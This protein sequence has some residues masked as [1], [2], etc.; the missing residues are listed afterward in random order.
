MKKYIFLLGIVFICQNSYSFTIGSGSKK[1][2]FYPIAKSLCEVYNKYYVQ[3]CTPLSTKGSSFNI[4]NVKE[5]NLDLGIAQKSLFAEKGGDK[6]QIVANLH[7]EYFTLVVGKNTK[8]KSFK[9]LKNKIINIGN[10]G[11]GSRIF[12]ERM[13]KEQGWK[14]KDFKEIFERKS[15]DLDDLICA[16]KIDA[17]VY[18][19]GHPNEVFTN[20]AECEGKFVSLNKK[21]VRKFLK[22][23]D[24]S[25][26]AKMPIIY[27]KQ[28]KDVTTIALPIVLIASKKLNKEILQNIKYI[29]ENYKAELI[30]LNPLYKTF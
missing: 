19:V 12:F 26:A 2:A 23:V 8:I 29:L 9:D 30:A 15:N 20:I 22:V 11:S 5:G 1:A 4:T 18:F 10:V 6:L 24:G 27:N 3:E 25:V 14:T 16:G 13:M 17:A 21:E 28:K 7:N